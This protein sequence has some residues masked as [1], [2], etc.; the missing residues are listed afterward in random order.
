MF[1]KMPSA[2]IAQMNPLRRIKWPP[3]LKI[4]T[5]LNNISWT[6]GPNLT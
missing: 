1:I 6:T 4:D 3:E 2:K 5:S